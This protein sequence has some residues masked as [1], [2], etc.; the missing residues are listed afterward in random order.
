[1]KNFTHFDL[2][3]AVCIQTAEHRI[4]LLFKY[5]GLLYLKRDLKDPLKW[6]IYIDNSGYKMDNVDDVF[7]T[8]HLVLNATS[9]P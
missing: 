9:T 6:A 8:P 7:R 1:M 5:N 2:I 4:K 3:D